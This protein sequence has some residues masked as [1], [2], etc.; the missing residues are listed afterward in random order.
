[1]NIYELIERM[2]TDLH[3]TAAAILQTAGN[4]S[5]LRDALKQ[6]DAARIEAARI[7]AAK[8]AEAGK[9]AEEGAEN[10]EH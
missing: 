7:E 5:V 4:M 1:M 8:Q 10:S 3:N 2:I 6:A 9:P